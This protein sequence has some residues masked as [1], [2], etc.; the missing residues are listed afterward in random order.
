MLA[1]TAKAVLMSKR[2]HGLNGWDKEKSISPVRI[3][4]QNGIV[5]NPK[6]F[7]EIINPMPNAESPVTAFSASRSGERTPVAPS[8]ADRRVS[9]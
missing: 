7:N 9:R 2:D 8:S 4:V 3:V 6:R 5:L 1:T